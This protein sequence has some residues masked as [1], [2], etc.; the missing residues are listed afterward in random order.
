LAGLKIGLSQ[1]GQK[2]VE[3]IFCIIEKVILCKIIIQ[4]ALLIPASGKKLQTKI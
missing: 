2:L 4:V 1:R 3:A